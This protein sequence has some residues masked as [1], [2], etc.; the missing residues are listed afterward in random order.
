MFISQEPFPFFFN[1]YFHLH[2]CGHGGGR[3]YIGG[4]GGNV[5]VLALHVHFQGFHVTGAA[6]LAKSRTVRGRGGTGKYKIPSD[7]F[8]PTKSDDCF[9]WSK[10]VSRHITNTQT[11]YLYTPILV[12]STPEDIAKSEWRS[13][14]PYVVLRPR[15]PAL[16]HPERDGRLFG[17]L[18][19][20]SH[21]LSTIRDDQPF[22]A[23]YP[24]STALTS[25]PRHRHNSACYCVESP[26]TRSPSSS[27][28]TL[29]GRAI[30]CAC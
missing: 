6:S 9:N 2:H 18:S 8:D 11:N 30:T 22:A 28:A 19:R 13:L 7:A 24:L 16:L 25:K 26:L 15:P 17:V 14:F 29:C 27:P 12:M 5:N 1:F 20:R 23:H 10:S 4:N 21:M 3:N